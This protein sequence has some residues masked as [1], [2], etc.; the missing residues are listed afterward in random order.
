MNA[1]VRMLAHTSRF[2]LAGLTHP[3]VLR[4]RC[5][6]PSMGGSEPAASHLTQHAAASY[7]CPRGRPL[8]VTSAKARKG[9]AQPQ[10][11]VRAFAYR[12]G[13]GSRRKFR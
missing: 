10:A 13:H 2:T 11:I 8:A 3:G 9:G 1:A 12:T 6:S 7:G 5:P 4:A